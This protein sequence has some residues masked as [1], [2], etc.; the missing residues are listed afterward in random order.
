[1]LIEDYEHLNTPTYEAARAILG[2]P[3][4]EIT[5]GYVL[6]WA[7]GQTVIIDP[8]QRTPDN[9]ASEATPGSGLTIQQGSPNVYL[10]RATSGGSYSLE[11]YGHAADSAAAVNVLVDDQS[12]GTLTLGTSD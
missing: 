5:A 1:M 6:P 11:L 10:L 8:S 9:Y 2:A 3:A 4:P 7:P 12:I